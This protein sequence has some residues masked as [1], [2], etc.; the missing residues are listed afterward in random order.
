MDY[1]QS[2]ILSGINII[3][4]KE[5][6]AVKT[7][8][9][10]HELTDNVNK[11]MNSIVNQYKMANDTRAKRVIQLETKVDNLAR[12]TFTIKNLYK[13]KMTELTDHL[14]SLIA[15]K[16]RLKKDVRS[17]GSTV[18]EVQQSY[19]ADYGSLVEDIDSMKGPLI[20]Y[21]SDSQHEQGTLGEEIMRQNEFI[22]G[23]AGS[24]DFEDTAHETL[25]N[26]QEFMD[27]RRAKTHWCKTRVK[28]SSPSSQMRQTHKS[29]I[30]SFTRHR[31]QASEVS[32]G[33][34]IMLPK[35]DNIM[36]EKKNARG[37]SH[38]RSLM[39]SSRPT[40]KKKVL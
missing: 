37:A 3:E 13:R 38:P 11:K 15:V 6:E 7:L 14:K 19:Q 10:F 20:D 39:S 9:E 16:D 36:D 12:E 33:R 2:G 30:T 17:I 1:Q 34:T 21:I 27:T 5:N 40:P 32:D 24:Q 22:R 4:E 29:A 26:Y 31:R 18:Q 23:L 35:F 25:R 28:S 8:Q